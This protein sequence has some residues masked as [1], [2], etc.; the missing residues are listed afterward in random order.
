MSSLGEWCWYMSGQSDTTTMEYYV[1]RYSEYTKGQPEDWA[2]GPRLRAWDGVDQLARAE[3][4][5][6]FRPDSRRAVVQIFDRS[7]VADLSRDAPC[8]CVLQF[9]LRNGRLHQ[10]AYM[11][12]NDVVRG[13]PLD[14]FSFTMIQELLAVRLGVELGHYWHVVG[15]MHIY[16]EDSEKAIHYLGEGWQSNVESAMP[17]MPASTT[18]EVVSAFLDVECS[19]RESTL[20]R[21]FESK[22]EVLPPYWRDLAWA[23]AAFQHSRNSTLEAVKAAVSRIQSGHISQHLRHLLL[24]S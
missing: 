18:W 5:L 11:R 1:P 6:R 4:V 14:V 21:D 15:S 19:L 24:A 3:D 16:E 17:P 8:T 12:S 13:L 7:D 10:V 22:V 2:Y 20:M 23:L 9:F